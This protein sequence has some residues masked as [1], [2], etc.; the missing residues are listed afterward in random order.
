MNP[1]RCAILLVED[2][3][4]HAFL[5]RIVLA[6]VCDATTVHHVSDG[7]SAITLLKNASHEGHTH[8]PNLILLDLKIPGMSGHDVLKIVK[9]H[10]V[11]QA[12][13]VVVLSTSMDREDVEVAFSFHA[14][15]YLNKP[16]THDQA[17]R[18]LRDLRD[19]RL[20]DRPACPPLPPA[21]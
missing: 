11:W 10:D 17:R 9:T 8:L 14:N 5:S 7:E 13:P 1:E 12:I 15:G 21:A 6:E 4:A 19:D 18:L 3:D 16:I 2:N 20:I